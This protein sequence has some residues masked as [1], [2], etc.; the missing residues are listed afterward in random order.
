M[1]SHNA[2]TPINLSA[3]SK[4]PWRPWDSL[5]GDVVDMVRPDFQTAPRKR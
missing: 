1:P 2:I 3:I 5:L 4:L